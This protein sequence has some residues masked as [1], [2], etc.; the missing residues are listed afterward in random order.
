M[1]MK[2]ELIR[3]SNELLSEC[4]E[5]LHESYLEVFHTKDFDKKYH[6]DN[7]DEC[8]LKIDIIGEIL[9]LL[10]VIDDTN[11]NQ[12]FNEYIDKNIELYVQEKDSK[13]QLQQKICETRKKVLD[14][15]VAYFYRN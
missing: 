2:N 7:I 10:Q 3:L 11:C 5:K 8:L 9:N 13:D 12:I 1:N 15:F 14:I 6:K 4:S